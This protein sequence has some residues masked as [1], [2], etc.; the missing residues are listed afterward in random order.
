MRIVTDQIGQDQMA[1]DR[2]GF[3]LVAAR[4]REHLGHDV[5]ERFAADEI[6]AHSMPPPALASRSA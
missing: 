2:D 3:G 6:R 1:S 4:G 5:L